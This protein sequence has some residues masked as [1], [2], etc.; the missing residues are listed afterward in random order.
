MGVFVVDSFIAGF[1]GCLYVKGVSG[2]VVIEDVLY[3]LDGF[4]IKIVR[5]FDFVLI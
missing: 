4:G 2:N 1:G 3:M 5:N